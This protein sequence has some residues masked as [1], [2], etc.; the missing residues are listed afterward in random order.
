[1][2]IKIHKKNKHIYDKKS[3]DV[4]M[5]IIKDIER[6]HKHK[7]YQNKDFFYKIGSGFA[8]SF[9]GVEIE[10]GSS[11]GIKT[12]SCG[13]DYMNELNAMKILNKSD[14]INLPIL[15][16]SVEHHGKCYLIMDLAE[17]TL[18]KLF[19][20]GDKRVPCE[21]GGK[22]LILACIQ[23]IIICLYNIHKLGIVHEDPNEENFLYKI[24]RE[25]PSHL[26]FYK[27]KIGSKSF[28]IINCKIILKLFDYGTALKIKDSQ[29]VINDYIG[30]FERFYNAVGDSLI[31]EYADKA[32]SLERIT[33]KRS[34]KKRFTKIKKN[35]D[36]SKIAI[37]LL[38]KT[39]KDMK[40][41]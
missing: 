9:Y 24:I 31:Y 17:N 4:L 35:N 3:K 23:Q 39:Q 12:Q 41:V 8:G 1:M 22:R 13:T 21:I 20:N 19:Y 6:G 27:E 30:A 18:K 37:A 25:D 32:R 40:N 38:Q 7:Q 34:T 10:E 14:S 11:Y 33:K 26:P 5:K 16:A 29:Q 15:F 36:Y 28:N 2:E